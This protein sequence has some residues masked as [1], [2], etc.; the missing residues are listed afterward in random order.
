VMDDWVGRD[1]CIRMRVM[2]C[3]ETNRREPAWRAQLFYALGYAL[4]SRRSLV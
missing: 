3:S 1:L 2:F 4:E